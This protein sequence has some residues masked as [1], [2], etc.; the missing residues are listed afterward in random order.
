MMGGEEVTSAARWWATEEAASA[1][2]SN[3]VT[4]TAPGLA[5]PVRPAMLYV[6]AEYVSARFGGPHR[7][8]SSFSYAFNPTAR[9]RALALFL[10]FVY[11]RALPT[12]G[13]SVLIGARIELNFSDGSRREQLNNANGQY[14]FEHVPAASP[15]VIRASK[16]GYL[17]REV[18]HDGIGVSEFGPSN[19][20]LNL[21]LM[22]IDNP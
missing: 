12:A 17:T 11:E 1:I 4:F 7:T 6:R 9:A 22:P 3:A 19:R 16:P 2:E 10:G 20:V 18:Q 21:I 14:A 5:R 13:G 8:V 15:F